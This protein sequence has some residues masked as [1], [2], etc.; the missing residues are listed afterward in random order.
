MALVLDTGVLLGALDVADRD[1]RRCADLLSAT[2]EELVIP[3]P[4]LV[5]ADQMLS[6]HGRL[7]GWASLAQAIAEGG[8][9]L[10]HIEAAVVARAGA[11]Q[12]KHADLRIGFVDAAVFLTCVE[13]GE[14]KVATLD[15]RHFSVLRTEDGRALRLLPEIE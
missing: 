7:Q 11:L 1:H 10:H 9:R 4:V 2:R 3:A 5:E 8:Y 13:L 14:D 6:K 15:H 12:T